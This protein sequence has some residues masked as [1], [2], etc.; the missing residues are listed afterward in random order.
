MSAAVLID[1]S[2]LFALL[3][4]DDA[5]H[6][7]AA[8]GW[9]RLLEGIADGN[10]GALTHHGVVV[11][12][13]ALVQRRLGMSALRDLHYGLLEVIQVVRPDEALHNRAVSAML[14]AGRRGVSLVDWTSFELMR[15]R[16]VELALAFDRDFL[17]QG[18]TL[19]R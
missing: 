8:A 1:T 13:S 10:F 2:A 14:A 18:F 15:E 12:S 19:F 17:D 9:D 3:D 6:E 11:E 16:S 4:R 7:G 5:V